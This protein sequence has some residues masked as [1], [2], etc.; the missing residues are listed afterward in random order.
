MAKP[1][2]HWVAPTI[3][4]GGLIAGAL[5]A[6]GHHLYYFHLGG[7]PVSPSAY[8][9]LGTRTTRQEFNVAVGTAFAFLVKT[10]LVFAISVAFLQ[11]FWKAVRSRNNANAATFLQIDTLFGALNDVFALGDF[12]VWFKF[13]LLMAIAAIAWLLPIAAVIT[14]STLSIATMPV[15]HALHSHETAPN[16]DFRS[17]NFV[18]GM[19]VVPERLGLLEG[20]TEY[21]Y[22]GPSQDVSIIATA[23]MAQ[24]AI[25]PIKPPTI[26][27]SWTVR[28]SGPALTCKDVD[29]DT[30]LRFEHNIRTKYEQSD[31]IYAFMS[32][33]PHVST[34]LSSNG[35]V[36]N[37]PFQSGLSNSSL[38]TFSTNLLDTTLYIYALQRF[39]DYVGN[40]PSISQ[41]NLPKHPTPEK[42]DG[43][44]LKCNLV[45]ATYNVA[46]SYTGT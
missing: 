14:P 27:A 38:L 24:G 26:N 2:I 29:S 16:L 11:I 6:L 3:M 35:S 33:F 43:T 12:K 36:N 8:S 46:F 31:D 23:V 18:A 40:A 15:Q 25:M 32:W 10:S 19:P 45:N 20:A 13:P 4:L 21:T 39:W 22:A 1:R 30:R 7:R 9:L 34:L 5:F 44:M 28:F 37:L 17:L 42:F 41:P